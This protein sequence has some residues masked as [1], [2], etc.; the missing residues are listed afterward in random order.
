MH[1]HFRHSKGPSAGME[2]YAIYI[3]VEGFPVSLP[4]DWL[5]SLML[6]FPW[7]DLSLSVLP[8]E[9]IDSIREFERM[10]LNLSSELIMRAESGRIMEG[11]REELQVCSELLSQ[12]RNDAERMLFLSLIFRICGRVEEREARVEW[13]KQELRA[14][15][16]R[17]REIRHHIDSCIRSFNPKDEIHF[18]FQTA[19][20]ISSLPALV[21]FTDTCS[22][23]RG[24]LA[25]RNPFSSSPYLFDPFS[26]P[27]FN[28]LIIGKSGSGKSFFAKL[29]LKRACGEYISIII[30]PLGEFFCTALSCGGTVRRIAEEGLGISLQHSEFQLHSE[31]GRA[32]PHAGSDTESWMTTGD[33]SSGADE[34]GNCSM[35]T[36]KF[37][38][39]QER[40][41]EADDASRQAA[42]ERIKSLLSGRPLFEDV[43][44]PLVLDFRGLPSA[45]LPVLLLP[46]IRSIFDHFREERGRKML[47]V[48]EAWNLGANPTLRKLTGSMM[49]HARH[50]QT[51]VT[52]ITQNLSDAVT[53][54]TIVNNCS[55]IFLFRH[56]ADEG[57]RKFFSLSEEEI[58]FISASKPSEMHQSR[59]IVF[60]EGR[61]IPLLITPS[62]EETEMEELDMN[63][64]SVE[65]HRA[66]I[67]L[68]RLREIVE[69]MP[70]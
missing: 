47:F 65:C 33:A 32:H 15:G 41:R 2:K 16:I 64:R 57:T 31:E 63:C 49:R 43:R 20:C 51:G 5:T 24:I 42:I 25:G 40:R 37:N 52:L 70:L 11:I 59:C 68:Y 50:F 12:L 13:L 18:D 28:T 45:E 44:Y 62:Q 56:E 36:G 17:F 14:W 4:R 23:K 7:L 60:E 27:N 67:S 10:E 19:V 54:D 39:G 21:P 30:D 48:D 1:L 58:A 38:T 66:C 55:R 29:M 6:R 46:A 3:L 69:A 34:E 8:R 53:D 9:K 35:L 26:S 22:G 61:R